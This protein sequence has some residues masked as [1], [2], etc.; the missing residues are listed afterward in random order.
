LNFIDFDD[1][2]IDL[3]KAIKDAKVSH[4]STWMIVKDPA[5]KKALLHVVS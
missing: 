2:K 5:L 3:G 4:L 1:D